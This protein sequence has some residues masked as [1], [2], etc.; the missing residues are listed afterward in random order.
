M[1]ARRRIR[2]PVCIA[3]TITVV[4]LDQLTKQL[5]LANLFGAPAI[6]LA[7]ILQFA[8]VFNRGAAFGLLGDAGGWQHYFF[9]LL[10]GGVSLALIIWLWRGA[11]TALLALGLALILGGALGNLMDRLIYTHVI[12]FIVVHYRHW[13]FPAFNLA[14]AA[15]TLGAG[16]LI[17]DTIKPGA[18]HNCDNAGQP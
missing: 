15:I 14:D 7:P 16:L 17:L 1:P 11:R 13:Y 2:F 8:L 9:I 18:Q 5:A 12:D 6:V 10:A 4:G 3:L